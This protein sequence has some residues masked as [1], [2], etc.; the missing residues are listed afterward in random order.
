MEILTFQNQFCND[1]ILE[2]FETSSTASTT[3]PKD[4]VLDDDTG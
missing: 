2:D 4:I 3:I 1:G